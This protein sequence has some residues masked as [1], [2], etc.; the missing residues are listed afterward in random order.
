MNLN[1]LKQEKEQNKHIVSVSGEIDAYTA[2][3]LKETLIPLTEIEG[4]VTILNLK[5]TIYMD[6]TGLGVIIAAL[7]SAEKHQSHIDVVEMT[8][9]VERLFMITGL[10]DLLKAKRVASAEGD[11]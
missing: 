6:S 7:K 1:I 11:I 3:K 4:A 9:R 8:P 2:P 10:M 5:E